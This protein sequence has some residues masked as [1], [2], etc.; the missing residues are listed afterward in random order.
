MKEFYT[1]THSCGY[2]L[3]YAPN[4]MCLCDKYPM[5]VSPFS[6]GQLGAPLVLGLWLRFETR[7]RDLTIRF[8]VQKCFSFS[9]CCD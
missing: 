7:F 1:C 9:L 4:R 6:L 2:R 5:G 8:V 3:Q